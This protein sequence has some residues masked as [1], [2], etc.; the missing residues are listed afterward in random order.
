MRSFPAHLRPL[1]L[2]LIVALGCTGDPSGPTAGSL[3]VTVHGLPTGSSAAI[4]VT[5]PG[6]FS[7]PVT[8]T[9]TFTQLPAGTY[10]IAAGDVV[11]GASD[12]APS[13]PSLTVAVNGNSSPAAE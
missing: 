1:S 5:G 8:A 11:V 10:S 4:T 6:G 12:Y 13:P 9:R 3:T 2:A 7:Q